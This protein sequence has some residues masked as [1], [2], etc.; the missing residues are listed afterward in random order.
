MKCE[1]FLSILPMVPDG[2]MTPK[3]GSEFRAHAAECQECAAKL[4]EHEQ[5]LASLHC[6]DDALILPEVFSENWKA[7]IQQEAASKRGRMR[8]LWNWAAAV[9]AVALIVSGTALMRSGRLFPSLR[10]DSQ[11]LTYDVSPPSALYSAKVA[12]N[13]LEPM[14]EDGSGNYLGEDQ[15]AEMYAAG[16]DDRLSRQATNTPESIVLRT[17]SI[18][19]STEQYDVDVAQIDE[20]LI[21]AGG[22]SEYS[23]VA[24]EPLASNSEGGRY[25]MMTLRIPTGKLDS[26]IEQVSAIGKVSIREMMAEDISDAY[27]DIKGRLAMYETQR[28]RLTELL[29]QATSMSDMVD[30]ESK[31]GEVQYTIETLIGRLNQWNSRKDNG[32]VHLSVT[33]VKT[34]DERQKEGFWAKAADAFPNAFQAAGRF[35]SDAALFF[36]MALPYVM[37]VAGI[38]LVTFLI[39][40]GRKK[41]K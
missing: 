6:L 3:D 30:I 22:W 15:E 20:L 35:L 41:T 17:A 32:V 8:N 19:L 13:A 29:T 1:D 33:E 27:F 11:N 7:T 37:I 2:N 5:L 39:A 28:D 26:F 18:S 16:V 4:A 24:G 9:A 34:L 12:P 36:V 31:L 25:A 40:R 14:M 38:G 21:M 23:S 10:L